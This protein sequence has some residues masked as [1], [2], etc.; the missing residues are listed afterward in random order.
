MICRRCLQRA[1]RIAPT[2]TPPAT[3]TRRPFSRSA[4]RLYASSPAPEPPGPGPEG[5]PVLSTPLADAPEPEA[6]RSA[7]KPGTVLKGLNYFKNKQDP[8]AKSDAAYPEWLWG[9][10]EVQNKK[11]DAGDDAGDEYSKSKKQ[12][13]I[14]AKRQRALEAKL[15]AE[16]NLE[17]LAP[18]VPLPEQSINL[19]GNEAGT[20]EGALESRQARED[21]R[22]AMRRQRKAAIKEANYLKSM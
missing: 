7:C 10:L 11:E 13:R 21:L 12:R 4:A 9:C 15:V 3:T 8:V 19:P 6:A 17:A 5:E 18:K 22:S 16:G 2:R 20:V 1:A 14:A